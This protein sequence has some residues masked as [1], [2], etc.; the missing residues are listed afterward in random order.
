[1]SLHTIIISLTGY[2]KHV[3]QQQHFKLWNV[4]DFKGVKATFVK[5][6][7]Q[8]WVKWILILFVCHV[9][10]VFACSMITLTCPPCHFEFD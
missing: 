10:C 3:H 2:V 1:M 6:Q 9:V 7:I 4:E 8:V 5:W